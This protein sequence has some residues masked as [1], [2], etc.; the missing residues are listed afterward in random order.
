SAPRSDGRDQ[1]VENAVGHSFMECAFVPIRPQV[2]LEAFQFHAALVGHVANLDRRKVRL[3]GEGAK[4]G[5]LGAV[6]GDFVVPL[7][8][9]IGEGFEGFRGLSRHAGLCATGNRSGK[10]NPGY[11]RR[12]RTLSN[13]ASS[14]PSSDKSVRALPPVKVA[15][16]ISRCSA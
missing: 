4:A 11:R 8:R 14:M 9:R 15:N 6:E 7:G 10:A 12:S 13:A 5:E 1:V 16:S 2:Q 3:P